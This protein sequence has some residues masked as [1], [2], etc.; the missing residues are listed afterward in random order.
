MKKS[1][2]FSTLSALSVTAIL[3]SCNKEEEIGPNDKNTVTL[4]F[5]NRVGSQNLEMGSKTYKNAMNEDFT[6]TMFNYFVSNIKLKKADGSEVKMDN[7][8]FL[9]RE[10]DPKSLVVSLKD[11]PAADYT[12]VSFMVGVDSLMSTADVAKRTGALDVA[13]YGD[14]AMYWSWNSG[15]IFMKFE[16][17][18]PVAPARANGTRKIEMHVGGYGGFSARTTNNLRT[19]TLP[20]NDMAK[21]RKNSS[22]EIHIFTDVLKMLDGATKVSFVTTN[23]VHSPTVATPIANNYVNMFTVDHV[24]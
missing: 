24:Q 9:V 21:V 13:S 12:S 10:A 17:T 7:Q 1:I 18:S 22:S 14:D 15:Y 16:G 3:V 8:Y 2:I 23:N 11:V 6:V 20:I 4:E 19:V 5:D